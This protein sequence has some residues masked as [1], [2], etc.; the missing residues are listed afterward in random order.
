MADRLTAI[1]MV[2]RDESLPL[3]VQGVFLRDRALAEME[4]IAE[5]DKNSLRFEKA[6]EDVHADL[7]GGDLVTTWQ[8]DLIA[9]LFRADGKVA[10][11]VVDKQIIKDPVSRYFSSV[12]FVRDNA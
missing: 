3:D 7:G 9:A 6:S 1:V 10:K 8:Q 12:S 5:V 4:K 2:P 11:D